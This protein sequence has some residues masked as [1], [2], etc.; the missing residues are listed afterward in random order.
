MC[1]HHLQIPCCFE[2]AIHE[3]RHGTP[4]RVGQTQT[5]FVNTVIIQYACEC[6]FFHG[7]G[8]QSTQLTTH[9]NTFCHEMYIHAKEQLF[10][11]CFM[12]VGEKIRQTQV[13]M[14]YSALG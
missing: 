6:S 1:S 10:A 4:T 2:T 7:F 11:Q 13:I 5:H 3:Y 8:N 12:V 9:S 14:S